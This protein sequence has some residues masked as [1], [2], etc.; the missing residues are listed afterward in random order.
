MAGE[1]LY[2][3]K[4]ACGKRKKT[5]SDENCIQNTQYFSQVNH[6]N[7]ME[8]IKTE[9]EYQMALKRLDEIFDAKRGSENGDELEL[10]AL[11]IDNY[12][13]ENDSETIRNS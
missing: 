11:L 5:G 9:K 7:G 2:R 13:K 4:C 3:S 10:L 1:E 8:D 12:E 6:D